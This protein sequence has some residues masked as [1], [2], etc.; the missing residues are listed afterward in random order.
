MNTVRKANP[1]DAVFFYELANDPETRSASING[2]N[3][4][5]E[6]HLSWFQKVTTS[7][8]HWVYVF[9]HA[10][11]ASGIVRFQITKDGPSLSYTMAPHARGLGLSAILLSLGIQ[12]FFAET[13]YRTIVGLIAEDNIR[14][15]KSFAKVAF[16]ETGQTSIDG[17]IFKKYE[18]RFNETSALPDL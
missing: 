14:S 9:E 13:H 18:L 6:D 12:K 16:S 5:W 15:Q 7:A 3:I 2:E 11:K 1:A 10:G 4:R 8:E 17:R